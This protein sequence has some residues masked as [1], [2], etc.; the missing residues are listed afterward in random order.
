MLAPPSA[1]SR[2]P[3]RRACVGRMT[4]ARSESF[5]LS[6]T[7]TPAAAEARDL[8]DEGPRVDDEAVADDVQDALPADAGRDEAEGEVAVFEL[9]GVAGVVAALVAC[10][11][12]EGGG[13]QVDDLPLPLVA[14]L[15]P[16][17]HDGVAGRIHRRFY[18]PARGSPECENRRPMSEPLV[19]TGELPDPREPR[20]RRLPGPLR[21]P[22]GRRR[23][24]HRRL[25]RRHRP[26]RPRGPGRL[27]RHDRL[28][29]VLRRR[30]PAR[31]AAAPPAQPRREPRRGRRRAPPLR[32]RPRPD[33]PPGELP[34]LR[35]LGR[36]AGDRRAP[37]RDARRGDPPARPVRRAPSAP[38]ATSR[39]S[40]TSRG[41]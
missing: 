18:P 32:D 38:R 24:P 13:D 16:D 15:A 33:A 3:S 19:L 28:R 2:A 36:P 29:E 30:H 7:S 10:D 4:W 34:R 31:Q 26:R 27:R 35:L 37:P 23:P 22:L 40:R 39:R 41:R 8:G 21:R 17:D 11:D 25:A 9:D 5:R 6:P 14:P 1:F 20:R 12:V